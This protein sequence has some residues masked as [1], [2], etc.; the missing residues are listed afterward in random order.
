MSIASIILGIL[1]IICG[2]AS[3]VSPIAA[4]FS[5][6]YLLAILLFIFG[7]FGIIRFFGKRALPGELLISILAV[8]I[9]FVYVFRPGDTPAV[10]NLIGVDRVLLYLIAVWFLIKG[11]AD[12]RISV[13]SRFL[14][15]SWFLG[16]II[17]I[18]S[19]ILGFYSIIYP[20]YAAITVGVFIG[21]L[22][23]QCGF[24]LLVFGTTTGYI[25]GAVRRVD[26]A[27]RE[28]IDDIEQ[29]EQENNP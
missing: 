18:L 11:F 15:R 9:G 13:R 16:V 5:A 26:K 29:A 19:V 23:I 27:I 6:V 21:L 17:G 20:H 22:F 25:K 8:I 3:V 1:L 14:N 24:E 2:V 4:Y 7:V 10:G 12:I 28:T